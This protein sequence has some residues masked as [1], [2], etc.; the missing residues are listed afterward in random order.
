MHVWCTHAEPLTQ[1]PVMSQ[2]WGVFP[3]HCVCPGAQMPVQ[4]PIEHVM[5]MHGL[6]V[7]HI[8]MLLHWTTPLP[9]H[10]VSFTAHTPMH[11]PM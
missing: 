9:E 10:F 1:L 6:G 5:F 8:P 11:A 2:L 7:P 3:L 4:A